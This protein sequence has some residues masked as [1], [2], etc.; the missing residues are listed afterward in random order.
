MEG[1]S[2]QTK[3]YN[4]QEKMIIKREDGFSLVELMITMVV[5]VLFMIAATNV[6]TGLLTQFKQQSRQAETNIEGIVGLEIM[7]Q[8]IEGAG[9]GLPWAGFTTSTYTVTYS[10]ASSN[11][12]SLN[13]APSNVPRAIISEN[14]AAFS[15]PNNIFDG[16]D[17]LAI[18]SMIVARN[19]ASAKWTTLN[20]NSSLC[21]T[22]TTAG[23][24]DPSA[25][26]VSEN[27]Q[28]NDRV[29]VIS[30]TGID[31]NTPRELISTSS[32]VFSTTFSSVTSCHGADS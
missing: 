7:R 27:L 9:Y 25:P 32:S 20:S 11:P 28:D 2:L 15:S 23:E 19:S 16:S 30:P 4:G 6:F 14:N 1:K 10:E 13:D 29:I 3:H 24:P 5:F 8:D 17:Y 18:R 31:N 26:P 12:F 22:W 21:R